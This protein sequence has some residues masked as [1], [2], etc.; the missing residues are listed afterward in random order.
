MLTAIGRTGFTRRALS[1]PFDRQTT[2]AQVVPLTGADQHLVVRDGPMES[3]LCRPS[4]RPRCLPTEPWSC[5]CYRTDIRDDQDHPPRQEGRWMV[6]GWR[7]RAGGRWAPALRCATILRAVVLWSR[8]ACSVC[9]NA[10]PGGAGYRSP[11]TE[12]GQAAWVPAERRPVSGRL[13]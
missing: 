10:C 8:P 9:I 6:N 5:G 13:A 3:L 4:A 7:P 12:R 11:W 2:S 1:E